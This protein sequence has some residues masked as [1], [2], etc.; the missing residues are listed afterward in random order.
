MTIETNKKISLFIPVY[1]EEKIIEKNMQVIKKELEKI[2]KDYEIFLVDDSSKDKTSK[3]CK[4]IAKN[5]IKYIRFNNGPSRRENL[6][7]AMKQANKEIIIF[8]DADL[9]TDLK[10]LKEL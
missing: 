2:T 9:A 3:I 10:Y 1:N 8:L 5:K 4:K 6:A 7:E